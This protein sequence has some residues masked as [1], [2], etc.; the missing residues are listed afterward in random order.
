M[1]IAQPSGSL[2]STIYPAQAT[3]E[4]LIHRTPAEHRVDPQASRLVRRETSHP[5]GG[6]T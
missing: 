3:E 4:A 1:I 6:I 2:I 5:P